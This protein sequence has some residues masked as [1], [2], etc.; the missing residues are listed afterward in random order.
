MQGRNLMNWLVGKVA[1][2]SSVRPFYCHCL[3][4]EIAWLC[5]QFY[6]PVRNRCGWNGRIHSS[7]GVSTYYCILIIGLLLHIIGVR[8][9][10][11][12]N[13]ERSP[14]VLKDQTLRIIINTSCHKNKPHTHESKCALHISIFEN[15]CN[16]HYKRLWLLCLIHSYED[17]M[18]YTLGCPE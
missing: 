13:I 10:E 5:A 8:V 12:L 2:S 15:S 16:L 17:G 1:F 6:T 11:M 4:M 14:C 3:F 9:K 7:E 18:L